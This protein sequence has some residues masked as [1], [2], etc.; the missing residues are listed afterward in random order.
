[1]GKMLERWAATFDGDL[2]RTDGK[3]GLARVEVYKDL[4]LFYSAART[5]NPLGRLPLWHVWK[6][7]K[8]LLTTSSQAYAFKEFKEFKRLKVESDCA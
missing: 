6:G 7:D 1:M 3:P 5:D 2:S 4:R 8:W